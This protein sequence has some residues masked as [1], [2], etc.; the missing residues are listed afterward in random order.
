MTKKNKVGRPRAELKVLPRG[1]FTVEQVHKLNP[2]IDALLTVYK[3]IKRLNKAGKILKL[4][5]RVSHDGPGRPSWL[6]I[7]KVAKKA[8]AKLPAVDLSTPAP[9]APVAEPV[10]A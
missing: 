10:T 5:E 7:R 4:K 6:F 2:H 9:A 8:P 3:C 1:K